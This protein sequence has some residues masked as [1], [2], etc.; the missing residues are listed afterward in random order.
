MGFSRLNPD[1]LIGKTYNYLTV[2][3]TEFNE[4]EQQTYAICHCNFC[5][6]KEPY[7]VLPYL[8]RQGS[9]KSCGCYRRYV[10][11]TREHKGLEKEKNPNY[12]DGRSKHP[13][14]GIWLSMMQRCNNKN[15]KAYQYYG[16]RGIKVCDGWHNFWNFVKWSDSIGGR[17][18]GYTLDRIDVNGNYEP[19]NCRWVTMKVQCSN[20]TDNIYLTFNG[21]TQILA[22]WSRELGINFRTLNNRINRGWSVERALTEKVHTHHHK[23]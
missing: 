19:S 5:N 16:K 13:L 21:K 22:E 7:K 12:I 11:L 18:K 14:Y 8:L 3:G 15:L 4:K 2:I 6:R 17:P 20:K 23:Q 9:S 1:E 10:N